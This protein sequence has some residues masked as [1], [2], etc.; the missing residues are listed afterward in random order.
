[1]IMFN[2]NDEGRVAQPGHLLRRGDELFTYFYLYLLRYFA[3]V[4]RYLH[5]KC[6]NF[7]MNMQQ[8][9]SNMWWKKKENCWHVSSSEKVLNV[10]SCQDEIDLEIVRHAEWKWWEKIKSNEWWNTV[11]NF[12]NFMISIFFFPVANDSCIELEVIRQIYLCNRYR[13]LVSQCAGNV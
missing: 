9:W 6:F 5:R 10:K 11:A 1:M 13:F 12:P 3:W 2:W 4:S 8:C 7:S